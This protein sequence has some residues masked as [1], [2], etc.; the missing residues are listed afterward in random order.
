[1][2]AM[3]TTKEMAA[4]L[5]VSVGQLGQWGRTYGCPHL[6]KCLP[7]AGKHGRG[8][9][10]TGWDP[11]EVRRWLRGT[12]R[13]N[14]EGVLV[15]LRPDRAKRK[16]KPDAVILKPPPLVAA[17]HMNIG[18][19]VSVTDAGIIPQM[20]AMTRDALAHLLTAFAHT[21]Q[22]GGVP[23]ELQH[24]LE[25]EGLAELRKEALEH[26]EEMAQ[27]NL[28]T[29]CQWTLIRQAIPA[30]AGRRRK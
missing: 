20:P 16:P 15:G 14:K 13:M 29:A 19:P 11:D 7:P 26:I 25:D 9:K 5:G 24:T 1:M 17:T 12:G 8:P 18:N 21:C 27:T 4:E 6:I 23:L 28:R 22:G 3:L 30:L 2:A 10:R